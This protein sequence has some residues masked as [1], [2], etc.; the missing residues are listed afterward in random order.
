MPNKISRTSKFEV[1]IDC[2]KADRD[3]LYNRLWKAS[4]DVR[5]AMNRAMIHL[6]GLKSGAVPWPEE[7]GKIGK[8]KGVLK[9]VALQTLCYRLMTGNWSPGDSPPCYQPTAGAEIGSGSLL[10]A[11]GVLNTRLA[12]DWLEI[13]RGQKSAP[14]FKTAPLGTPHGSKVTFHEDGRIVL[15]MWPGQNPETG[16]RQN[17]RLTVRP[18]KLDGGTRAILA[19]IRE[20]EYKSGGVHLHWYKPKG[21]KGKWMLTVQWTGEVKPK[22]DLNPTL[23]AGVDIGINHLAALVVLD[24]T[25]DA[26]DKTRFSK[27]H[28]LPHPEQ[29]MRVLRRRQ[30]E[31]RQRRLAYVNGEGGRG[32]KAATRGFAV[33]ED[34]IA[35]TVKTAFRQAATDIIARAVKQGAGVL[36]IED[37]TRWS[38]HKAM[39][40]GDDR[41]AAQ[42]AKFRRGYLR[43]HQG[44]LAQLLK[45]HGER[46]GMTVIAVNPAWTSRTCSACGTE[47]KHTGRHY[48]T[49]KSVRKVAN[50]KAKQALAPGSGIP[51]IPEGTDP[52]QWGR[53]DR[54][55]FRC[56]CGF[57]AHAD[58]NAAR[59]VAIKGFQALSEKK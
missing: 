25:K 57:R 35:R 5:M 47:W 10:S 17:T 58:V 14:T 31:L 39:D 12:T 49:K 24:T 22:V 59:N 2:R 4:D 50:R 37:H 53:V 3:R 8:Y 46:E 38:V 41:T 19:A 7:E 11:A 9:K 40:W 33:A 21:R 28:L 26:G 23:V 20:G 48:Q 1:V 42:R 18:R 15:P 43:W 16:K 55:H 32:R 51:P 56:T 44:L 34:Q 27:A 29:V 36:V 54:D 30:R 45:E 52:T 6:I 13:S